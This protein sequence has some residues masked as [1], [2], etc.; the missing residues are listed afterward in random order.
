[1]RF[2][3]AGITALLVALVVTTCVRAASLGEALLLLLLWSP[4]L[5]IGAGITHLL[6]TQ[7]N[8]RDFDDL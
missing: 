6:W 8:D 7:K 1:M 5:A 4:F 3:M 2:V